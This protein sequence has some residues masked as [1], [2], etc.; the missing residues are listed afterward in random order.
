MCPTENKGL[1]E[2]KSKNKMEKQ[3]KPALKR[4]APL[5]PIAVD[6]LGFPSKYQVKSLES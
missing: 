2:K 4:L 6:L 3:R 1:L 5:K